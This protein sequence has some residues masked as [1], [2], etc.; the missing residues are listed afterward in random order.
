MRFLLLYFVILT[1]SITTSTQNVLEDADSCFS[2]VNI[3]V[4]YTLWV[5]TD[6]PKVFSLEFTV[7]RYTSFYDLM[8]LAERQ[9]PAEFR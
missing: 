4:P 2:T 8:Q 9:S 7:P 3:T 6:Q 1:V 5:G